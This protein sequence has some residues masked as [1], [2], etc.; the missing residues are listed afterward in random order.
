MER[1]K[2]FIDLSGN[3]TRDLRIRTPMLRNLQ[4]L[5]HQV[6]LIAQSVEQMSTKPMIAGSIPT[7]VKKIFH[8]SMSVCV[9]KN[10]LLEYNLCFGH[11]RQK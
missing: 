3:R 8:L 2:N 1:L 11:V 5:D 4:R 7:Q 10:N 9:M 6:A